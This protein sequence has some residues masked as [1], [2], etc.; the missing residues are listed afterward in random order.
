MLITIWMLFALVLVNGIAMSFNYPVRLS[1]IHALVG[2]DFLTTAISG[3]K[4]PKLKVGL[5]GDISSVKDGTEHQ[6]VVYA[7]DADLD[8][9][10]GLSR[11]ELIS[12]IEGH[13][14]GQGQVTGL[15][16]RE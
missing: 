1:I 12:A 13:V 3:K 5:Y 9:A 14:I 15:F 6:F 10:E 2:H 8:L 16:E 7:L 11:E 4:N